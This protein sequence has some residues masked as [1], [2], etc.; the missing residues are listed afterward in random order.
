[1]AKK[2]SDS[3]QVHIPVA[4]VVAKP[5]KSAK[6]KVQVNAEETGSGAKAAATGTARSISWSTLLFPAL[7]FISGVMAP[8]LQYYVSVSFQNEMI[9]SSEHAHN[10]NQDYLSRYVLVPV[11]VRVLFALSCYQVNCYR[12]IGTP[13][14]MHAVPL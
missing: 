6:G 11:P 7:S 8:P 12:G 13:Y 9:I 2:K 1:M 3:D 5:V 4:V 14:I 10:H